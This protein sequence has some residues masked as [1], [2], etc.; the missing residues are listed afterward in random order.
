MKKIA[1][2]LCGVNTR[3]HRINI[4]LVAFLWMTVSAVSFAQNAVSPN[5]GI[6]AK[7]RDRR[8][9]DMP[10]D[11]C[12]CPDAREMKAY[13][14]ALV[15][16]G[17]KP[18]EIYYKVAKR[19][20]LA[21]VLDNQLKAQLEKRFARE[22]GPKRPQIVLETTSFNFG[23]VNK[24]QGNVRTIF[25][26][27]NK[28]NADLVIT[29]LRASC[30]CTTISL[31]VDKQKSPYF[32]NKGAP[33]D[34]KMELKPNQAGELEMVLDLAH[35]AV[36][37]GDLIREVMITSNDPLYPEVS[38]KVE[39][40]VLETPGSQAK[41]EADSQFSG[42]LIEGVRVIELKASQYKFEPDPI[43]VKKGEK[44]RVVASSSDVTHGISIPEFKLNLA[45]PA[46]KESAAEFSPD[47]EGTF[48]V[49]CSV[50]CG[51]G[52]GK[53]QGKVIVK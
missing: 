39:A 18:D 51:T 28:G 45:I 33:K 30:V 41:N 15:E 25:K 43:V 32:D 22:A 14:D 52:H 21:L 12:D 29:N 35:K 17:L 9:S 34:W 11:Q 26:L 3:K 19:Y 16:A 8:C 4:I 31:T 53:M 23:E 42:K 5:A 38:A 48:T 6:Y 7:F 40:K 36:K 24:A 1:W 46:G 47:K 13:I 44:V 49:Y 20:S 2:L 10:L 50:Y 27:R 37:A